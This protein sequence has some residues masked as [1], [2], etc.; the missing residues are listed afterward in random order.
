M[1]KTITLNRNDYH[2]YGTFGGIN[3]TILVRNIFE[4]PYSNT[5][6]INN[7][8]DDNKIPNWIM[9]RCNGKWGYSDNNGDEFSVIFV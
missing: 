2:F 8:D 1:T 5:E 7:M 4:F 3:H 9:K 6:Q